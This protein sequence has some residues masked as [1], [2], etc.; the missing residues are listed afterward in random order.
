MIPDFTGYEFP[1]WATS[2]D[3]KAWFV[4]FVVGAL[5][6]LVKSGLRWFKRVSN[7]RYE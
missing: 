1:E 7:E 2:D 4:G 6:R 5:V 3:A